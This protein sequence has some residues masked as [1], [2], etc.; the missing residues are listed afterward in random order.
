M[1][2]LWLSHLAPYPPKGGV[3]QRAYNLIHELAH[4]HT[5]DLIAF[6][7][8]DLMAPFFGNMAEALDIA[9]KELGTFCRHIKFIPIDCD[10]TSYGKYLLALKSLVSKDPYTIN[11]LK[12]RVFSEQLKI[13]L[14]M[15]EYDLIHFDTISLIPYL[16][17]VTDKPVVLDHHNIES[18]MLLRRADNEKNNLKQWYFKQEGRRL[19]TIEKRVCPQLSLNITCSEIDRDRLISL[20]GNSRVEEVPNGV[21]TDYF[22]SDDSIQ[23]QQSLIFAGTLSWYPNIEAIRFIA[24]EIWPRIRDTLPDVTIDIIGAHPPQDIERVGK[25]DERFHVHGFVDDVRPFLDK[26]AVYVCPI[27]DGGGTKLKILDALAMKKAVV[28]HPVA[29]EGIHVQEGKH[30]LFADNTDQYV[31]H[32]K[33][34]LKDEGLRYRLGNNARQLIEQEYT[35]SLIGKNLSALYEDCVHSYY[36]KG[37]Q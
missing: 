9:R 17:Y 1:N 15:H 2:I 36:R 23:Q 33:Q 3:L 37:L 22:Q 7:Q 27:K 11:W 10:R 35:Y 8:Q 4:Y 20:T 18:H 21:D 5:V 12:S 28:A 24:Y 34:L 32:I 30:V 19:E 29:C 16:K 14:S 25:S 6:N 31:C 26:A 13:F